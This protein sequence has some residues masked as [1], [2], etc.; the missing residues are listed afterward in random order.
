MSQ[1]WLCLTPGMWH[2]T[3]LT[4]FAHLE[5]REAE[6]SKLRGIKGP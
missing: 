5:N 2:W 3:R 4:M 1:T 6:F